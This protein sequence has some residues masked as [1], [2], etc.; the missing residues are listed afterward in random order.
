MPSA[1]A[2]RLLRE[3]GPEAIDAA[4]ECVEEC[5]RLGDE[6]SARFW[7]DVAAELESMRDDD[8]VDVGGGKDAPV[9]DTF[10][11]RRKWMLVQKAEAFWRRGIDASRLA[12]GSNELQQEL[13]DIALQWFE[14]S[15][16]YA[17]L[18]DTL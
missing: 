15:R 8:V 7:L 12:G 1:T 16:Q 3:L 13:I 6:K 11:R 10:F 5:Q 17:W 18:A 14:L 2:Q 4:G 9:R